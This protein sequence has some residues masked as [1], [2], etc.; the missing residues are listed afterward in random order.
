MISVQDN[1]D[2]VPDTA[3]GSGALPV[4]HHGHGYGWPLIIRLA[5]EITIEKRRGGGK[6]I[7]LLVPLRPADR[8]RRTAEQPA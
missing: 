3:Y 6:T 5:R 2:V 4:A 1:S 8:H 7:G